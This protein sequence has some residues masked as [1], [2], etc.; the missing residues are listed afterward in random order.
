[1]HW[2]KRA[3]ISAGSGALV[4]LWI[5]LPALMISALDDRS[6]RAAV[7]NHLRHTCVTGDDRSYS[8]HVLLCIALWRKVL[9]RLCKSYPTF[10]F[11]SEC[12]VATAVILETSHLN[13]FPSE[14][15]FPF[16]PMQMKS[17]K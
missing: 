2:D 14:D 11:A 10:L 8:R 17:A 6:I 16:I 7:S 15:I 1:M 9:C 13:V 5:C 3:D 4:H 12:N